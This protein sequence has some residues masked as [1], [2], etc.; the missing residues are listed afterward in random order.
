MA[1]HPNVI[2]SFKP[3][4]VNS[5]IGFNSLDSN[6]DSITVGNECCNDESF[7]ELDFSRFTDLTSLTIGDNSFWYVATMNV[8]GL[9][10]LERIS[11]GMN[12]FIFPQRERDLSFSVKNCSSLRELKIG[13]SSFSSWDKI[14]IENVP[15]LEVIEIGFLHYSSE[16]FWLA[17]LELKSDYDEVK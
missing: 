2:S 1:T 7:T 15:F 4:N 3:I 5:V 13:T 6:T 9:Q 8:I 10:K 11:I 12:S 14:V 16:N 17:S